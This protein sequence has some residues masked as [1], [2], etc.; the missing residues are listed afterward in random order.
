M[1]EVTV[2][3]LLQVI[4]KLHVEIQVLSEQLR[5]AKAAIEAG[6]EKAAP[7]SK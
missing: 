2:E 7:K 3:T 4:G 5:Q 6:K 1:T